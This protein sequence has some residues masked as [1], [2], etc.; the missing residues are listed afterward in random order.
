MQKARNVA[1]TVHH[2][3]FV[4]FFGNVLECAHGDEYH[5]RVRQPASVTLY[6][7]KAVQRPESYATEL[8]PNAVSSE[9][10]RPDTAELKMPRH[11]VIAKIGGSPIGMMMSERRNRLPRTRSLVTT[12]AIPTLN[13]F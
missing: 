12:R 2:R 8:A 3:G 1:C 9:F 4:E 5:E 7:T 11:T 13:R 6:A 10:I